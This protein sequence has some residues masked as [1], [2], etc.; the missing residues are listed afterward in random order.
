[1]VKRTIFIEYDKQRRDIALRVTA[2]WIDTAV[3]NTERML[4]SDFS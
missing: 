1:M 4:V 3:L 2:N